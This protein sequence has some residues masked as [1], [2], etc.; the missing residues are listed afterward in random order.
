[1]MPKKYKNF[2]RDIVFNNPRA[3]RQFPL[4]GD[5][6]DTDKK[7][8]YDNSQSRKFIERIRQIALARINKT[9]EVDS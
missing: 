7:M 1:M 5:D 4:D 3:D 6:P 8:L 9:T 2:I